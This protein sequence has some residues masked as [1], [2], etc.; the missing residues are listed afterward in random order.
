M[1]AQRKRTFGRKFVSF[2]QGRISARKY[3]R[4]QARLQNS[5]SRGFHKKLLTV[6]R[7]TIHKASVSLKGQKIPEIGVISEGFKQDLSAVL[8]D[9]VSRVYAAVYDVN[10]AR[11]KDVATKAEGDP[12]DFRRSMNFERSVS[13]YF[14]GRENMMANM[15]NTTAREILDNIEKMRAADYTLDQ[16]SAQLPKDFASVSSRRANVIARTETHSAAGYANHDYHTQASD[17]YGIQMVKQWVATSDARTRTAHAMMNGAKVAMDEDFKMPNGAVMKFC[18]DSRGGA[19]NVINCRCVTLYHEPEDDVIDSANLAEKEDFNFDD[20]WNA[21]DSPISNKEYQEHFLNTTSPKCVAMAKKLP[22]PKQFGQRRSKK[23]KEISGFYNGYQKN[24]NSSA[25]GYTFAHEYGHHIDNVLVDADFKSW[26]ESGVF[27]AAFRKDRKLLGLTGGSRNA[28]ERQK[29]LFEWRKSLYKIE[30]GPPRKVLPKGESY[31]YISDVVD[32]FSDGEFQDNWGSW[33]H[34]N[35]YYKRKRF[36]ES[37]TFANM[38]A[39]YEKP[40]W[41]D[42]KSWFPNVAEAFEDKLN[43]VIDG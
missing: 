4:E 6:F 16:I 10:Y 5:L 24:I 9:H 8:K 1:T 13:M 15:T 26:S 23:T 3:V 12:F 18:G 31:K 20:V 39:L 36:K 37:E 40:E 41:E 29:R 33:G 25:E 7:R 19:K 42:V 35:S 21:Q 14:R 22:K 28:E 43:E 34:G 38:Y 17:S 32:A 11:Y 30:E 27:A 2:S